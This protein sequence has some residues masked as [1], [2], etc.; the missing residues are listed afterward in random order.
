MR[1]A[2]GLVALELGDVETALRSVQELG[3]EWKMFEQE[4]KDV[5]LRAAMQSKDVTLLGHFLG[6]SDDPLE[7]L[8]LAEAHEQG[9][10]AGTKSSA[11]ALLPPSSM[12]KTLAGPRRRM[13]LA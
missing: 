12:Q 9:S 3:T 5:R 11:G 6:E 1:Y 10:S 8:I 7:L 13:R 4:A 2:R